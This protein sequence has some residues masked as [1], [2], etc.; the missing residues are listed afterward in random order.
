MDRHGERK[1]ECEG[2]EKMCAKE[3]ARE[4]YLVLEK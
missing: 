1:R 4:R 2:E 3:K